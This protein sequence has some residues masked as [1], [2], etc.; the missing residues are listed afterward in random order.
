MQSIFQYIT[1]YIRSLDKWLLA[2]TALF[3]ATLIFINYRFGIE[4][5][6]QVLP[7]RW[8]KFAAFYLLYTTAFIVPYAFLAF[9]RS[10]LKFPLPFL[11]LLLIAPAIFAAK[12]AAGGWSGLIPENA[13]PH[14]KKYY[15][16]IADLP[17]RLLIV[18]ICLMVIKY[19]WKYE[20]SFWGLTI[21]NF[22]IKPYFIMLLI[23]LPLIM[24]ASTQ[25]DFLRMYPKVKEIAFI[26]KHASPSWPYNF[27]YEFSYGIDFI[28]IELFFRGFLVIAFV[29]YAGAG[30]ILPMAAFYCTV[31]FGKPL[32]EC[33]SSFFGGILLGIITYNTQTILGGLMVHLGIAWMMEIGGYWGNIFRLRR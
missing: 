4:A 9:A 15:K 29:R 1:D 10:D 20:G 17:I 18:V 16:I 19:V 28:T 8:Q 24:F 6:F 22:D 30:A 27:L 32:L 3:V 23:M 12:V 26:S 21:K 14:W 33:I 31:H 7:S 2:I 11:A 13:L 25:H 5:R